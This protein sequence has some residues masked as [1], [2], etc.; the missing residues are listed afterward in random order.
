MA[1]SV[2]EVVSRQTG[3]DETFSS[4]HSVCLDSSWE[5]EEEELPMTMREEEEK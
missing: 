1:L 3:L 2:Q 4:V 5:E